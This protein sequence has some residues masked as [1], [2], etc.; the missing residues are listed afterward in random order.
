MRTKCEEQTIRGNVAS[1]SQSALYL[2]VY[3]KKF[4]DADIGTCVGLT[5]SCAHKGVVCCGV[6]DVHDS[7]KLHPQEQVRFV[8]TGGT[9]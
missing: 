5:R 2:I 4:S 8:V 7:D 1:A 3:S 6:K 9:G